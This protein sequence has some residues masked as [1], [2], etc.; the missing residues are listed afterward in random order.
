MRAVGRAIRHI[1]PAVDAGRDH[2]EQR[3]RRER[4]RD[5]DRLG[6]EAGEEQ[7]RKHEAVLHP[8]ARPHEADPRRQ[9]ARPRTGRGRAAGVHARRYAGHRRGGQVHATRSSARAHSTSRS[10]TVPM[11]RPRP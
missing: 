1:V 6:H 9:R 7:R 8:L 5:L 3:E 10:Y 2:A 11:T 4:V